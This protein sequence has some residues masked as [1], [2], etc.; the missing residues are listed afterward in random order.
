[1]YNVNTN[2]HL[3][4]D[5][6]RHSEMTKTCRTIELEKSWF[7]QFGRQMEGQAKGSPV[8]DFYV[9][10]DYYYWNDFDVDDYN[11]QM[12]MIIMIRWRA[13]HRAALF[14]DFDVDLMMLLML[15]MMTMMMMLFYDDDDYNDQMDRWRSRQSSPDNDDHDD[16]D[17]YAALM[18]LKMMIIMMIVMII[19]MTLMIMMMLMLLMIIMIPMMMIIMTCA[20]Y[21]MRT[22]RCGYTS[23]PLALATIFTWTKTY[24]TIFEVKTFSY[25]SLEKKNHFFYLD[26]IHIISS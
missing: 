25:I 5:T 24:L 2:T 21:L 10:V 23:C 1:M 20:E 14:N 15:M 13:R 6:N 12:M 3:N 16:F 4:I 7:Q 9:D 11:D 22:P 17:V 18:F 26:L 8:N 19:M